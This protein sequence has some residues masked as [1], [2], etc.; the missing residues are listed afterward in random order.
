MMIY[1]F[2]KFQIALSFNEN[3]IR[4]ACLE[5]RLGFFRWT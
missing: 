4:G 5:R 2:I 1:D 3:S